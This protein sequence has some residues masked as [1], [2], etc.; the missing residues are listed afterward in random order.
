MTLRTPP[1]GRDDLTPPVSQLLRRDRVTIGSWSSEPIAYAA[2]NPASGGVYRIAGSAEQ[3]GQLVPWS[4][5]LKVVRSPEPSQ[6]RIGEW[7][8]L[9]IPEAGRPLPPM[10]WEREP[11]AY[12]TGVLD[13]LPEGLAAPRCFGVDRKDPSVYWVWLEDLVDAW[14]GSWTLPRYAGTAKH[15]GRFNGSYLVGHPLPDAPWLRYGAM[16]AWLDEVVRHGEIERVIEA[17]WADPFIQQT[18][19][20]TMAARLQWCWRERETFLAALDRLPRTFCHRDAFP[21]NLFACQTPAG[22]HKLVAVDWAEAGA[23]PVGEE[24]TPLVLIPAPS[25]GHWMGPAQLDGPVFS[26]YVQ[27]LHDV[28]WQGDERVVRLGYAGSVTFRKACLDPAILLLQVVKGYLRAGVQRR[29]VA[30]ILALLEREAAVFSFAL[31]LADEA[32]KLM[33]NV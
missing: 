19:P 18:F 22:H 30:S 29:G 15:L 23:G 13:E 26:A 31:D 16:R 6:P 7:P 25:E 9:Y 5:V 3:N 10:Y 33:Q 11:L 1:I 8:R 14:G 12:Q 32:R 24:I 2:T 27:G 20:S 17:A 4:L 21:A 28:G